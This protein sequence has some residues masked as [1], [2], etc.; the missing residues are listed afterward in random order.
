MTFSGRR[1]EPNI[2]VFTEALE[3]IEEVSDIVIE[4]LFLNYCLNQI[5]LRYKDPIRSASGDWIGT[6]EGLNFRADCCRECDFR[7]Q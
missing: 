2:Y 6:F 5:G 3:G 1:F 7:H 4:A